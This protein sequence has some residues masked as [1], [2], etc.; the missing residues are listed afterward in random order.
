MAE[1]D[2]I[3]GILEVVLGIISI[4]IGAMIINQI[5]TTAI[6]RNV[7]VTILYLFSAFIVIHG[8]KRITDNLKYVRKMKY[9]R[10]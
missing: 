9:A 7:N 3:T 10:K 1:K 6:L 2:K 4:A 5:P 8:L